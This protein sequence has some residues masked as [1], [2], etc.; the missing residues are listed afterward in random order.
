M[1]NIAEMLVAQGLQSSQNVPDASAGFAKGAELAGHIEKV[2]QQRAALEQ[3]KE[4]SRLAKMKDMS[5]SIGKM[6]DLS[7]K[8]RTGYKQYLISK[9]Q[10]YGVDDVFSPDRIELIG[11]DEDSI[12]KFQ[13]L[14]DDVAAGRT[15]MSD[16][17][18]II[19][20]DASFHSIQ[21]D[22]M[23]KIS[24]AGLVATK[25]REAMKR[26][27]A[28]GELAMGRQLQGQAAAP[29]VKLRTD[30]AADYADFESSGG[31][32]KFE[33]G[34]SAL[35]GVAKGLESGK[36]STRNFSNFIP[37]LGTNTSFQAAVN[38]TKEAF[39]NDAQAILEETLKVTLGAQFTEG[40][41][42]RRLDRI[43]DDKQPTDEN[44][45]RVRNLIDTMKHDYKERIKFFKKAGVWQEG[46]GEDTSKDKLRLTPP[47]ESTRSSRIPVITVDKKIKYNLLNDNDKMTFING[48]ANRL[49]VSPENLR[50]EWGL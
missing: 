18:S 5:D 45:R 3:Q 23:A 13:T 2:R 33:A 21:P 34:I 43:W 31:K 38:P 50:K 7:P 24:E 36:V 25:N 41:G 9:A 15:T 42:K 30:A 14:V 8:A 39:K 27:I 26:T 20:D 19:K 16:A 35:E 44:A 47:G 28:A 46:S 48:M 29:G 22:S 32:N 6:K 12:G 17:T 10:S 4:E 49:G 11:T 37:Y 1:A 40:E